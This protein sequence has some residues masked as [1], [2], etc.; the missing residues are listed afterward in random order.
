MAGCSEPIDVDELDPEPED[1]SGLVRLD[2][3]KRTVADAIN[4]VW[5]LKNNNKDKAAS[6]WYR[7]DVIVEKDDSGFALRCCVCEKEF[8]A[9]NPSNFWINHLVSNR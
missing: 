1:D 8:E 2:G 3:E 5:V 9:R 4:S 6:Y 7:T